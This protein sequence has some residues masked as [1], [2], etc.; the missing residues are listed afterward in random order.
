ML[1]MKHVMSAQAP[2]GTSEMVQARH[3]H[4]FAQEQALRRLLLA[5][6]EATRQQIMA[7]GQIYGPY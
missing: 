4:E 7:E 3:E 1:K 5:D 2:A 6:I